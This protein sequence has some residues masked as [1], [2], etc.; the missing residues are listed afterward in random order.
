MPAS[1]LDTYLRQRPAD[2]LAALG[3]VSGLL[4]GFWGA[5]LELPVLQPLAT[6][7][8]LDAAMLPIGFFYGVAMAIGIAAWVRTPWAAIIVVTT[9]FAPVFKIFLIFRSCSRAA[10]SGS[11]KL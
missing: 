3:L 8:A 5:G 9:I 4:S 2:V 10:I 6:L 11:V 7:F 1:T